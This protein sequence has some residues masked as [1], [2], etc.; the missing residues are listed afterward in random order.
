MKKYQPK[1]IKPLSGNQY[2]AIRSNADFVVMTGGTGGGKS[3]ALAYAPISYLVQNDG[4]KIIWF[5]RNVGDFFDAGKVTDTLKSMYPLIDRRF[6][7]Q[8]HDPIGEVIKSQEDMGVKLYNGSEIKFQHLAIENREQIDKIFKGVQVK[9]AIVEECNKFQWETISN[10]QTRLRADTE[11]KA[12]IYLAQNPERECF[13]RKMCGCGK[14][15]GGWIADDGHPIKEMDGR[16]RYFYIV[17][18]NLDEIY[19][20]DTKQEVYNQ[21]KEII[22]GY[23]EKD[24]DLTYEDFILS[25]VFF[26]FDLRDNKAMLEK[27]KRY[28]ALVATSVLADSAYE[29]NWNFSINDQR[30]DD[31]VTDSEVTPDDIRAMF[32]RPSNIGGKEKITVDVA[33]TGEDNM[34]MKHWIGYH[35]DDI[36]YVEKCS[37]TE[38]VRR[39]KTFQLKHRCPDKCLVIDV[40]GFGY[41]KDVFNLTGGTNGGYAFSGAVQ[42]SNRGKKQYERFKDEAAHLAMQMIKAGLITYEPSLANKRYTHQKLKREGA[43]TILKHMIFE[44]RIFSFDKTP[45]GRL[46]FL[47][48]IRQHSHLKGFSPDLTDNIIMLCGATCYD[49]YRE[50]ATNTGEARKLF[51][52]KDMLSYLNVDK[53]YDVEKKKNKIINSEKILQILSN[54]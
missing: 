16:V 45:S 33:T 48:K 19:W 49:C 11:G 28:R 35:C 23:L 12:Q 46:Q 52:G 6:K 34:V 42:P 24:T 14:C 5:M 38:A 21:C 25:M 26:T 18:G 10:F 2:R 40:Q 54:I 9:K 13:I 39:I 20:G 1:I 51:D 50:L 17:K 8:P 7:I 3:F 31:E 27:N 37:N 36:D 29:V 47:G 43:T 32:R 53:N 41:L 22:D 15:G 30:Q 4:A 44:S